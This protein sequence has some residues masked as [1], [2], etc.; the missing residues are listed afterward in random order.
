M[1]QCTSVQLVGS[2]RDFEARVGASQSRKKKDLRSP[3]ILEI[4]AKTNPMR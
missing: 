4:I 2:R 1:I 3:F